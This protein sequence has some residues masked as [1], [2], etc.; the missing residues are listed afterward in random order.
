MNSKTFGNTLVH[1]LLSKIFDSLS[2]VHHNQLYN[3]Y[4]ILKLKINQRIKINAL[5]KYIYDIC[6]IFYNAV[7]NF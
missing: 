6:L 3:K 4:L 5:I 2:F 7:I 1:Y